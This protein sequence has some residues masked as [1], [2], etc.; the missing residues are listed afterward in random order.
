M[1]LPGNSEMQQLQLIFRLLG[2]PT[3]QSWPGVSKLPCFAIALP[4]V[5]PR[6]IA[7]Q[8]FETR[9]KGLDVH[10]QS[11]LRNFLSL[12]PSLRLTAK[13]ALDDVY[14]SVAPLPAKLDFV[15]EREST[16]DGSVMPAKR[17]RE[18]TADM[19][20]NLHQCQCHKH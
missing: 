13:E 10:A 14:F 19:L 20:D 16:C 8:T 15:P 4:H 6:I 11:L 5:S 9:I 18:V 3:E 17:A 1:L 2:T 12:D 7:A